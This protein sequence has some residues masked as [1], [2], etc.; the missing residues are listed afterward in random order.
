MKN[1]QWIVGA[2]LLLVIASCGGKP[3]KVLIMA[4]GK[5][6]VEGNMIKVEPGTRHNEEL[7][8][9]Q[10]DKISVNYGSTTT[11]HTVTE[12]GL[13]L[14]NIKNDTLVGSY[15]RVGT[16]NKTTR[17]TQ[18]ELQKNIDSLQQLMAGANVN[19]TNRNFCIAPGK[20]TMITLNT[21]AQIIG[22][23]L[24][25]PA[26]FEGGKEYEIYK[27]STNKEIME[28]VDKLKKLQ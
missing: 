15:K 14:L 1:I 24:K 26:S 16:E 18:E 23:Y 19:A 13:Y 2:I 9:V 4:S 22:P 12:P 27:F 10:G 7:M 25:M 8:I 28:V 3:K 5:I 21:E 11:E 17:V 20:L 6:T